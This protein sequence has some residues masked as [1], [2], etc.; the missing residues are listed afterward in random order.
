MNYIC[1]G[2]NNPIEVEEGKEIPKNDICPS[3]NLMWSAGFKTAYFGSQEDLNKRV[4]RKDKIKKF[5]LR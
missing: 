2:C 5:K 4:K 3:C 1:K